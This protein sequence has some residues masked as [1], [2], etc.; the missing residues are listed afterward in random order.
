MSI[1]RELV[2]IPAPTM[3]AL[4]VNLAG[5]ATDPSWLSFPSTQ[6]HRQFFFAK[7]GEQGPDRLKDYRLHL[8]LD[9]LDNLFALLARQFP[10]QKLY[11]HRAE[12]SLS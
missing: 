3:A 11:T 10:W 1:P 4:P 9:G 5:L 2:R 8:P 7:L 6:F 12:C